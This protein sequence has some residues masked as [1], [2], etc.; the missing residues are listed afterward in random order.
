MYMCS[1]IYSAPRQSSHVPGV[2]VICV[3]SPESLH[4][5]KSPAVLCKNNGLCGRKNKTEQK[6]HYMN[7]TLRIHIGRFNGP[8]AEL[9]KGDLL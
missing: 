5:L 6:S 3:Q 8:G 9:L 7:C 2:M 1:L 4:S